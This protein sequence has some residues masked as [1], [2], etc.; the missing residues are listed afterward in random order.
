MLRVAFLGCALVLPPL[1][2]SAL[3][4][5]WESR[6]E[7]VIAENA[8]IHLGRQYDDHRLVCNSVSRNISPASQVFYP[9]AVVALFQNC[10]L[11]L[12]ST[13]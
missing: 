6:A 13:L 9:G 4:W 1:F 12:M 8:Q 3:T 2:A 10:C 11:S 5:P 7:N